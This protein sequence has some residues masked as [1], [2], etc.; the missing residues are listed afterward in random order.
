[1]PFGILLGFLAAFFQSVSY[2]CTKLFIRHHKNDIASL[3]TVAHIIMG[4]LSVP[5]VLLLKPADMPP[6]ASYCSALLATAGFY[7]L[8]QLFLF[9]ALARTEASRVSPLL[10]LK[11]IILALIS[12]LFL[13]QS[14]TPTRWAA[15]LLS[16]AAAFLLSNTGSRLPLSG[17]VLILLACLSYSI[18][19]INIKALVDHFA[20]LG[21]LKGA[22]LGTGLTYILCGLV[23]LPVLAFRRRDLN[24][25]TFAW[26][27]PFALSWLIAVF[28]LFSCFALIGVVFGNIIQ[29]TRGIISIAMGYAIAHM[30]FE[31]L[32]PKISRSVYIRRLAAALLMTAAVALYLL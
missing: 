16:T 32:E 3:L 4:L 10:G 19:D 31:R 1:M 6:F 29:S 2:L 27:A 11:I 28:F 26:S 13:N 7:L 30:G 14:M 12:V 21:V 23:A 17:I 18:S 24:V 9:A 5:L 8:G 15:V 22:M 20:Y 25:R